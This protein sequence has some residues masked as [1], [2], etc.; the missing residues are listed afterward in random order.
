MQSQ[1]LSQNQKQQQFLWPTERLQSETWYE[2]AQEALRQDMQTVLEQLFDKESLHQELAEREE[3][4]HSK[5]LSN[6][7]ALKKEFLERLAKQEKT[8][9][10]CLLHE[11][12]ARATDIAK[13]TAWQPSALQQFSAEEDARREAGLGEI[14]ALLAE[15]KLQKEVSDKKMRTLSVSV[16]S[17]EARTE[18]LESL[19]TLELR[20]DKLEEDFV[21]SI[22][23]SAGALHRTEA[24]FEARL[25]CAE[26]TLLDSLDSIEAHA[27]SDT[28]IEALPVPQ[29]QLAFQGASEANSM[30]LVVQSRSDGS[31]RGKASAHADKYAEVHEDLL[32]RLGSLK[33][34]LAA[35]E[36]RAQVELTETLQQM[37]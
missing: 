35:Q 23:V 9:E 8:M 22:D 1:R 19:A 14:V 27:V 33:E 17:V 20:V 18:H 25:A 29:P 11:G 32:D 15:A 7:A 10:Q 37:R 16:S 28:S 26:R 36:K 30:S 3:Q 13:L 31:S 2:K 21:N 24:R 6:L 12:E 34:Q 5:V 4:L